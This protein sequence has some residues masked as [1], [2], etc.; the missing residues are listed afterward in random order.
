M[1]RQMSTVIEH[2]RK[3]IGR[4]AALADLI[5]L[6][7]EAR[8]PNWDGYRSKPITIGACEIA[9]RFLV[10]LPATLPSPDISLDPDGEVNFAWVASR[11]FMFSISSNER[12]RLSYAGV[13][14]EGVTA[15][16]TEPFDDAI[17]AEIIH[18][19]KRLGIEV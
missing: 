13:F 9:F 8:T 11:E 12:G 5:R 17:P 10:A 7:T 1:Q 18:N 3:R 14:G 6:C 16:G 2:F 4:E 19:I 15:H